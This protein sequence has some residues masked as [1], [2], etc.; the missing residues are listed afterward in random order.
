MRPRYDENRDWFPRVLSA[1]DRNKEVMK[2]SCLLILCSLFA[3]APTFASTMSTLCDCLLGTAGVIS[4]KDV[5]SQLTLTR[6]QL[7][8]SLNKG[9]IASSDF[10]SV[11]NGRPEDVMQAELFNYLVGNRVAILKSDFRGKL[12][13]VSGIL[14][15]VD[16]SNPISSTYFIK[17]S[18]TGEINGLTISPLEKSSVEGFRVFPPA[19]GELQLLEFFRQDGIREDNL[20]KDRAIDQVYS[21][22]KWLQA[23]FGQEDSAAWIKIESRLLRLD[24]NLISGNVR[25]VYNDWLETFN[26]VQKAFTSAKQAELEINRLISARETASDGSRK[27]DLAIASLQLIS[28]RNA[29]II[30]RNFQAVRAAQKKIL[31]ITEDPSCTTVCSVNARI[32]SDVFG[33]PYLGK[34]TLSGMPTTAELKEFVRNHPYAK[35]AQLREERN[36]QIKA[37]F[38]A[39]LLQKPFLNAIETVAKKYS[40]DKSN[41][42]DST[43]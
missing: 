38:Q 2:I 4:C 21:D 23:W 39:L 30:G 6:Y 1:T 18:E 9:W 15:S 34:T 10:S 19:D 25:G 7:D 8:Y 3:A 27:Y 24:S 11:K 20:A 35:V 16:F 5:E 26:E 28:D 13:T 12:S 17:N 32:V 37:A 22:I 36:E 31:A 41:E 42:S 33:L 43:S 14:D 29:D 40:V